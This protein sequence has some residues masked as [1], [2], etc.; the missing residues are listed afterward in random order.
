MES[1]YRNLATKTC[2][3]IVFSWLPSSL[4]RPSQNILK[5]FTKNFLNHKEMQFVSQA[6]RYFQPPCRRL[7]KP[8]WHFYLLDFLFRF[9]YYLFVVIM[10]CFKIEKQL[11]LLQQEGPQRCLTTDNAR[12][13]N[14]KSLRLLWLLTENIRKLTC[15]PSQ[16]LSYYVQTDSN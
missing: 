12:C 13:I 4:K 15:S 16:L 6:K 10:L 14:W 5:N 8:R 2:A 11:H 3:Q 9:I 7:P 1:D